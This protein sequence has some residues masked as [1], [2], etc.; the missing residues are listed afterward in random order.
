M[1]ALQ[2]GLDPRGHHLPEVVEG[3][4]V[5]A[6]GSGASVH[7]RVEGA[8]CGRLLVNRQRVEERH[9]PLR[10]VLQLAHFDH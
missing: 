8:L 4:Y 6:R 9:R 10:A 1:V 5:V 2:R 3:E 7:D